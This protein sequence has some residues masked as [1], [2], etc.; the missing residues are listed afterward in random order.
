MLPENNIEISLIWQLFP[1]H[2]PCNTMNFETCS[3]DPTYTIRFLIYIEGK[4]RKRWRSIWNC[5]KSKIHD[6]TFTVI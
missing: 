3:I 5:S 2:D 4:K 6:L 1:R